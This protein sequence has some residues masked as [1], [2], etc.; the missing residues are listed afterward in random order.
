MIEGTTSPPILELMD[1][2]EENTRE[3]APQLTIA[4]STNSFG[5]QSSL[6]VLGPSSLLA[7]SLF[8][9]DLDSC[10]LPTR[11]LSFFDRCFNPA[12]SSAPRP[13]F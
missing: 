3:Y 2:A 8:A 1:L 4:R 9:N 7:G 13:S 6:L 11:C 5:A 10:R 12:A